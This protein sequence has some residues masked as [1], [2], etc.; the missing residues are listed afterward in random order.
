MDVVVKG[1]HCEISDSF[2]DHVEEKL[3]RLEKHDHR[4]IRLDVEVD[5][6]RN[7]RQQDRCVR[8]E[9]TAFSKGPVIRAE[10][11]ADDKR[12]ALD[13]AVD[14]MAAQMRR[15]ADRRR[16]HHGR[17]TPVSVS[18]ALA[19][20]D[21]GLNGSAAT[22]DDD[23]SDHQVGPLA[24]QGEGPLVVREKTHTA[25]PMDLSQ[26][27]YEMELVGHDFFLFVDDDSGRPSVV[28]RR[29]GYDYGVIALDV[30]AAGATP[31]GTGG[32]AGPTS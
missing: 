27:L 1:R 6:E 30:S 3:S 14:K 15:A 25:R 12:A 17:H 21:Q 5:M 11:C 16:V 22:T 8:V 18:Q 4:V 24:V 7:P 31:G 2:R 29:K 9:L 23:T 26:A 32:P 10:A 20:I 13:V 19:G 28:Y